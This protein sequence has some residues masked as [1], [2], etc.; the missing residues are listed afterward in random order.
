[1]SVSKQC[2]K[3]GASFGCGRDDARCWCSDMP[4]LS[5]DKLLKGQDCVCLD[6]LKSITTDAEKLESNEAGP[7]PAS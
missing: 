4:A 7:Y 5:V 6:C 3:C 1:M 2:A